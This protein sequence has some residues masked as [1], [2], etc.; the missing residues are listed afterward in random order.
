[1][2][3]GRPPGRVGGPLDSRRFFLYSLVTFCLKTDAP[4]PAAVCEDSFVLPKIGNKQS[5]SDHAYVVIKKAILDNTF[6][7][8]DILL[9]E[10]IAEMLGVSRTPLRTALKRLEFEKLVVINSSKQAVVAE[11]HHE[12]MV[13]VFVFRL[14]VEPV[15]ARLA[16]KLMTEEHFSRIEDCLERNEKA[17]RDKD[18]IG[19]IALELEFDRIFAASLDN[20]FLADGIAMI[21]SYLQRFLALSTTILSDAPGSL[22]EHRLIFDA[23]RA[24]DSDRAEALVRD[25]LWNV[26]SRFRFQLPI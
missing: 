24:R 21:H 1:M 7:P 10:T 4:R 19:I 12:D 13:K 16:G 17:I 18:L 25:H 26:A 8:R 6:K 9:E 5:L 22:A 3:P 20:E 2:R 14:G 11:I 15:A 23:L